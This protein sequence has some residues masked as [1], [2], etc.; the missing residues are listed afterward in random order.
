MTATR[1]LKILAAIL[2]V[3]AVHSNS[4]HAAGLSRPNIVGARA[5][6]LGGAFTA[7]AD[8]PTA[9]W[10]N[11]AGTAF[12]G[13]TSIYLGGEILFLQRGYA[14]APTSP[15]GMAGVTGNVQENTSPQFVPVIGG[16]TRFGFGRTKPSRFALSLLVYDPYGGAISFS[17]SSVMQQGILNTQ[18]VDLEITPTVAYQV[19]DILAIA[20]GVRIGVNLFSVDDSESAFHAVLSANGVGIGGILGLMVKPHPLIQVG[21]V[22]R[23]PLSAT[24]TGSGPVTVAGQMPANQDMSLSVTWPQSAGLG[25]SVNIPQARLMLSLQGDWTGWS[26]V[27]KLS[28]ILGGSPQDKQ[29]HFSDSYALHFGAQGII[30]RFLLARLGFAL[31]GNAI[32]NATV[33]RENQDNLKATFAFGFGLHFWKLFIDAA[34]EALLPLPAR[35]IT[36]QGP[37]NEA[38]VYAAHIYTAELSAQ[39]R[40]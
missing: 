38:G 4:A 37:D 3:L 20:A 16:S 1:R 33:R 40:F 5:I 35:V 12:Y 34:F 27:Q 17:P 21:A 9:V 32:P 22:Y 14:P 26:S 18:I 13:D 15:L 10:Y 23:T 7:V 24:V 19:T 36:T 25:L 11:P 6:G 31:D 29:M 28:I 8:D 2:G 30:T 39:I